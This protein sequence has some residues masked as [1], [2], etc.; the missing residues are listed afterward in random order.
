MNQRGRIPVTALGA[1]GLA[2]ATAVGV[3]VFRS[4]QAP[5]PPEAKAPAVAA[6]AAAAP[7]PREPAPDAGEAEAGPDAGAGGAVASEAGESEAGESE[8][9][10]GEPRSVATLATLREAL[11][12]P[13]PKRVEMVRG[14]FCDREQAPLAKAL[15]TQ[16]G[17]ALRHPSDAGA[18][19]LSAGEARRAI[20][21]LPWESAMGIDQRPPKSTYEALGCPPC[22]N[23]DCAEDPA[24]MC[25][26]PDQTAA[27]YNDADCLYGYSQDSYRVL[28]GKDLEACMQTARE[29][30]GAWK[31]A[32]A[33]RAF[34]AR[35][36]EGRKGSCVPIEENGT[37][38]KVKLD[39]GTWKAFAWNPHDNESPRYR[40][41]RI[42]CAARRVT[43]H[44]ANQGYLIVEAETGELIDGLHDRPAWSPDGRFLA[45]G[46]GDPEISGDRDGYALI[47]FCGEPAKGCR[48]IWSDDELALA[49]RGGWYNGN[50]KSANQIELSLA[51]NSRTILCDCTPASCACKNPAGETLPRAGESARTPAGLRQQLEAHRADLQR[52]IDAQLKASPDVKVGTLHVVVFV[53][54]T[55]AIS[56]SR[57]EEQAW[58]GTPLGKCLEKVARDFEYGK[59]VPGVGPDG[60]PKQHDVGEQVTIPVTVTE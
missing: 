11:S 34:L 10:A 40:V 12:L 33:E 38:V 42:D 3:W 9:C 32:A 7:P 45:G 18:P 4:R 1:L 28:T 58:N 39:D 6:P 15:L 37:D 59:F 55:G 43:I 47:W 50:W 60:Q 49:N 29:V 56:H 17:A 8:P 53:A 16:A 27:R 22:P 31:R 35:H 20:C 41:E 21:E 19:A 23:E 46:W 26:A 54:A 36:P 51:A 25:G 52:C 24:C 44:A 30:N 14:W 2:V 57:I 13:I 5:P 48:K